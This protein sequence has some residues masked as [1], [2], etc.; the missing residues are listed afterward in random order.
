MNIKSVCD[1]LN[2][3]STIQMDE[4]TNKFINNSLSW[5]DVVFPPERMVDLIILKKLFE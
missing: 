5:Y 1:K 2:I 3:L 4:E